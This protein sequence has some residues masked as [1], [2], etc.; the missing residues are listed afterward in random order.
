[1]RTTLENIPEINKYLKEKDPSHDEIIK[2]YSIRDEYYGLNF[3]DVKNQVLDK[4]GIS[5]KS[6]DENLMYESRQNAIN[7]IDAYMK[8]KQETNIIDLSEIFSNNTEDRIERIARAKERRER[9]ESIDNIKE[10]YG[11]FSIDELS[12]LGW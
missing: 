4:L 9:L 12:T 6:L 3:E 2:A 8:N 5:K 1:M 7:M 11:E 10:F